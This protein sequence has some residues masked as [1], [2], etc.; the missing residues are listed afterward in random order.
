MAEN[1]NLNQ[2]QF[3]QQKTQQQAAEKERPGE[4]EIIRR[5]KRCGTDLDDETLFCP[6]CGE[7]FG[8]KEIVCQFCGEKT[9]KEFCPHCAKRVIPVVCQKCGS[10]SV[11]DVCKN[12]GALLNQELAAFFLE[13]KPEPEQMSEE[14]AK[15]VEEEFRQQPESPEFLKF[16]KRLIERQIL[17]EERDYFN[18]R[19]KRIIQVFG[20]Q[21]FSL[22]LPDPEEE[23]FRM[24]AYAALEKTVIERQERLLQEEWERLF[25]EEK[26]VELTQNGVIILKKQAEIDEE[27]RRAGLERKREE[28]EKRYQELLAKVEDEVEAFRIAEEKRKEE[29][30]LRREEEE[31]RRK[32]EA[33]RIERE[34]QKERERQRLEQETYEN[35]IIGTYYWG[36]PSRDYQS[37]TLRIHDKTSAVCVHSCQS[38]G[39]SYG[40]FRLSYDGTNVSLSL[41]S[42][43]HKNCPLLHSNLSSFSGTINT[44]GTII[45][46]YWDGEH[47]IHY[48]R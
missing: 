14:E 7:Q 34:R 26:K 29:E 38:H 37:L 25:P 32:A 30:R 8:G 12:C 1:E 19:E 24:K 44:S 6:Q 2:Q 15:R 20:T 21:P 22:E 42:L 13:E 17:L 16:Q 31:R 28:M 11:F 3:Q 18:K 27:N 40:T 46:G 36:N 23:A 35:R 47:I 9:T 10:E 41:K 5:C 39:D 45:V 33:E 4:E 43:S 48:K